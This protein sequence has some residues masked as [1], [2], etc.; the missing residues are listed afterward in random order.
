M[1]VNAIDR[2]ELELYGSDKPREC[3]SEWE[4]ASHFFTAADVGSR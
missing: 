4:R 3:E 1:R 2:N